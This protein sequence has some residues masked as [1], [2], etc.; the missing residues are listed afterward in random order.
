MARVSNTLA[1]CDMTIIR[2]VKNYSTGLG[3]FTIKIISLLDFQFIRLA[4]FPAEGRV[5]KSGLIH[6][7]I[8]LFPIS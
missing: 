3:H 7:I 8:F 5:L 4:F 6:N 2:V 1:Y